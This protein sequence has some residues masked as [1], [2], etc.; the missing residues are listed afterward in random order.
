MSNDAD[1]L[2]RIRR[3]S[4]RLQRVL[5]VCLVLVPSV[6]LVLWLLINVVPQTMQ[7]SVLPHYVQLPLPL[8][9]RLLG[10]LAS[11]VPGGVVMYGIVVLMR[12]FRQYEEGRVF[13]PENVRCFRSL[14]RI[15]VLWFVASILSVPVKSLVLTLHHPPGQHYLE[16]S[17]GSPDLTA[18]LVGLVVGVIAWVME[19]GRKLQEE[20]DY[21]I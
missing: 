15:L 13:G 5:Q 19:E 14:S 3:A 9:G 7:S 8:W 12:L 16:L 11:M 10:F 20:Q 18:L 6:S 17:L 1:N 4:R 21:T 2:Q